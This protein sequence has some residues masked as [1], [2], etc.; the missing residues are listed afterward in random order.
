[1]SQEETKARYTMT[2]PAPITF[3]NFAEAKAVTK[4]SKPKFSCNVEL[5]EDHPD[6]AP[7]KALIARVAREA[8]PG[9]DLGAIHKPLGSGDR[10][11]D[12]AKA[13]GKDREFSRGKLV[14]T[15]RSDYRPGLSYLENGRLVDIEDET[16]I[17]ARERDTFYSGALVLAEVEFVWYD[18]VGENGTP[19]VTAYLNK[20][21]S[22]K[23][24][25]RLMGQR[26]SAAE[27]FKGYVGLASTEDLSEET[28]GEW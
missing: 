13:K 10:L 7:I 11:A 15:A 8:S 26:Q 2:A 21:L 28:G 12:K 9:V 17:K 1:M 4:G 20:V 22:T 14:L 19:G 3:A 5:P 23:K 24:G 16:A 18:A 25:E 27:T 6:V